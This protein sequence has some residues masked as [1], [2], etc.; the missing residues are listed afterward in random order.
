MLSP[1]S[2][3]PARE[4]SVL[5]A[6]ARPREGFESREKIAKPGSHP[7]T[8][9]DLDV[10]HLVGKLLIT[11]RVGKGASGTV[12]RALHQ[13]LGIPVAVKVLHVDDVDGWPEHCE[14]LKSE[15][16][17]LARL[18]HPH[19]VRVWDFEEHAHFPYLVLEMVE[20]L[21]LA[22]LIK[23][24]GRLRLPRAIDTIMQIAEGLAAAHQLGII[25]RDIKP[26]NILLQRDGTAK[27]A[28]FGLAL[29]SS[30]QLFA[31]TN[32]KPP[33][34]MTVVGTP[35]YM[36][37]E[38]FFAPA[39]VDHRADIY[40]LGATFYH[41]L[42]GKMLFEGKSAREVLFKHAQEPFV[43]PEELVPGL[44][45]SIAPVFTRMLAKD[46]AKRYQSYQEL[47]GAL[48]E[49]QTQSTT[50]KDL[51]MMSPLRMRDSTAEMSTTRPSSNP[52][53]GR[54]GGPRPSSADFAIGAPGGS[55]PRT[56]RL[57][58]IRV[59]KEGIAAARLGDKQQARQLLKRATDLD[60]RN[61][62]AWLWLAGLTDS[63]EEAI[64]CLERV[65]E[66]NPANERA[67]QGL[68][69]SC[70][71]AG[72]NAA[73][74]GNKDRARHFLQAATSYNELNENA[75]LGLASVAETAVEA[76]KCLQ[77]VLDINPKNERAQAGLRWHRSQRPA[78]LGWQCPLCQGRAAL[79]QSKCPS[80]LAVVSLT[81]PEAALNAEGIEPARLEEATR[82]CEANVQASPD[83]NSLFALGL[84]YLNGKRLR[85]AITQ[86]Q[87]CLLVRPADAQLRTQVEVLKQRLI[88]EQKAAEEAA[89]RPCI[90]VI[91]D[92]ATI[93]KLVALTLSKFEY[94]VQE[95]AD[96]PSALELIRKKIPALVLL[97][98]NMPGMDG[99]QVC[100]ALKANKVTAHIPVIML[101]G[102]DGFFDK[103]RGKM[104]GC[105]RYLSKPFQPDVLVQEVDKYCKR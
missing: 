56:S 53:L 4:S 49:V 92:S 23:Q 77:R 68:E 99:Y 8:M 36:A 3:R 71:Q 16:R 10:G 102:K 69:E 88:R 2:S 11:D 96:G 70:F 20:G 62:T 51:E 101:S 15:A 57:D 63:P 83:F 21:S 103:L 64:P 27:I 47:L 65:R 79:A 75:W 37:P 26:A 24:S 13:A 59:L 52:D 86:F 22:E 33:A 91:D 55:N 32:D 25:H 66:I 81:E 17:L 60:P 61:E 58:P 50:R 39:T 5:E 14:K 78:T 38:M 95:A 90:L 93:R 40:S 89:K 7:E 67:L 31:Q 72:I 85:D 100:K 73:H 87:G 76:I 54:T 45:P 46:P 1:S 48:I 104:A 6:P 42:T 34:G 9:A 74:K 94:T 44:N 30:N 80:C 28:D 18:N 43:Q 82:R 35:A 98:I 97:D 19:V 84:A 105:T 12:Y 41:A 29:L